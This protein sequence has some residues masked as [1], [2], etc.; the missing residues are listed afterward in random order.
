ME[1]LD[2]ECR[3]QEEKGKQLRKEFSD[4]VHGDFH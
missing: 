1:I 3:R 4:E 2:K